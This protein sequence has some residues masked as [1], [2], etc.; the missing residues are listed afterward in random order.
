MLGQNAKQYS[1]SNFVY[2]F[3]LLSGLGTM[4]QVLKSLFLLLSLNCQSYST[5]RSMQKERIV[6]SRYYN[7]VFIGL[8]PYLVCYGLKHLIIQLFSLSDKHKHS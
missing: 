5:E 6:L 2:F 8:L 3:F 7:I 4:I 1:C